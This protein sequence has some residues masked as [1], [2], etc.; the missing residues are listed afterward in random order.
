MKRS[1]GLPTAAR[2]NLLGMKMSH[3]GKDP[4]WKADDI[5]AKQPSQ[6]TSKFLNHRNYEIINVYRCHK[7]LG[8]GVTVMNQ[9]RANKI[10]P[11]MQQKKEE[12]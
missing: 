12:T 10:K 11:I 2:N 7:P 6:A 1:C 5:Q 8:L 3:L 9:Q 4:P